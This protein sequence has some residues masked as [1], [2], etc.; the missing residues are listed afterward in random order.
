MR[1]HICP[2]DLAS[3]VSVMMTASLS[4]LPPLE[5]ALPDATLVMIYVLKGRGM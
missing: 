4:I 1:V 2:C 5:M 3:G